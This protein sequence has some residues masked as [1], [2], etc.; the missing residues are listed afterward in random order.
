MNAFQRTF[1]S[2]ALTALIGA[3][4]VAHAQAAPAIDAEKQKLIDQVIAIWHP[5]NSVLLAA[6]RPAAQ[7]MEQSRIALQQKQLPQPKLEAAL[8][9]IAV[10]AQKYVDTINPLIA[11]SARKA[12]PSTVVPLLAQTFTTDELKQLLALLQS[13]VKS[14][15]E[16][17]LPQ[18]DQALG[19]KVQDDIGAEINKDI[20]TMNQSA[21]LKLRAAAT[22]ADA[23]K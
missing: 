5:E 1:A 18:A 2:A 6:Q 12:M 3:A 14:K 11:T 8:K 21:G 17:I 19:K 13:P 23:A 22:A 15:F 4:S 7:A 9:D 10:D 16:K 20:Q